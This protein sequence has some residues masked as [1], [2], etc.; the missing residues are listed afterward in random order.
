MAEQVGADTWLTVGEAVCR[1]KSSYDG[2]K[3][4]EVA[5]DQS[6]LPASLP[7]HGLGQAGTAVPTLK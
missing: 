2:F 7:G 3:A 4:S 5:S 6:V 1:E